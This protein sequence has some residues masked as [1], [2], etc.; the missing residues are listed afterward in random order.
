MDFLVFSSIVFPVKRAFSD[1]LEEFPGACPRI[2]I[3]FK[4]EAFLENKHRHIVNIGV[5]AYLRALFS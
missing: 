1:R 4:I 3:L 2:G 5:Y